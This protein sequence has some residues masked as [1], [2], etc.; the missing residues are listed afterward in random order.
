[1]YRTVHELS[2]DE[3]LELK[4]ALYYAF[5]ETEDDILEEISCWEDIPDSIVINHYDSISFVDD[6]FWCNQK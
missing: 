6:D 4:E 3:F 2:R 5:I 1:M